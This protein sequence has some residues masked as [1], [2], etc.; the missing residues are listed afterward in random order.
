MILCYHGTEYEVHFVL[1]SSKMY[2]VT[3][4]LME[5]AANF[6][7]LNNGDSRSLLNVGAPPPDYKAL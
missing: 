2:V 4:V 1:T 6:Y 3:S 5:P 7:A